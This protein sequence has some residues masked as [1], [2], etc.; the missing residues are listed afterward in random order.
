MEG[1]LLFCGMATRNIFVQRINGF[2][3]L[4]DNLS[5]SSA[6]LDDYPRRY[7]SYLL[8]HRHYYLHIY[9]FV[10]Q[11]ALEK[12]SKQITDVTLLDYGCGNGLLGLFA[13]YCGIKKV[14]LCDNVPNFIEGSKLTAA[15]LELEIDKF[16]T[17]TD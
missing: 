2:A 17:G 16:I 6:L 9:A 10:L 3:N 15:A 7:L 4:L 11:K 8:R 12:S 5:A 14:Y 13:K 1:F